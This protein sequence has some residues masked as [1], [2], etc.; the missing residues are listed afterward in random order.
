MTDERFLGAWKLASLELVA[1]DGEV[2]YPMGK[3][4]A[5]YIVY[6]E[7]GHMSVAI[8]A[9]NRAR[10]ASEDIGDG[11][12]AE[13]AAA[14]DTYLSYCGRFEIQ[15]NTV[16]H[17]IEVSFF[18]NWVVTDQIR[19]F[20]FKEEALTLRTAPDQVYGKMQTAKLV[21]RRAE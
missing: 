6:T 3:Q 16:V 14:A 19:Y 11:T 21:W 15:G 5:G 20:E 1:E 17:H 4:P 13:K 9:E 18:P 10:F 7:D 12:T 2:S 8:M